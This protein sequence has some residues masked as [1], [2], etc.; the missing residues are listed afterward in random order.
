MGTNDGSIMAAIITT[1]MPRKEAMVPGHVC[2]GIRIQ[3]IDI[4][5]PP[6][7]GIPLIADIDPHQCMVA[8]ALAV[9]SSAEPPKK[10][11][12]DARSDTPLRDFSRLTV[13][14]TSPT[15]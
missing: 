13:G 9:K 2:P 15:T 4:V 5:Q 10:A 3:V 6:G 7:I 12:N 14:A 11:R 8:T 1:H